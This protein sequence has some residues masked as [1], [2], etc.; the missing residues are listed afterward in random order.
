MA[1]SVT[2][3]SSATALNCCTGQT[4]NLNYEGLLLEDTDLEKRI[5]APFE[6]SVASGGV[7]VSDYRGNHH[8]IATADS[9]FS[10]IGEIEE[11]LAGCRSKTSGSNYVLVEGFTGSRYTVPWVLASS[12]IARRVKVYLGGVKQAYPTRWFKDNNDIVFYIGA[13]NEELEIFQD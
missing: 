3:I 7:Y 13:E 6:W 2:C 11:F 12:E 1:L 10:T 8:L 4:A 5:Y 9:D